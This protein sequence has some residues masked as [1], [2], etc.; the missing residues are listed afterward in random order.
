[1]YGLTFRAG[2]LVTRFTTDRDAA[3]AENG[4]DLLGLDHPLVADLLAAHRATPSSAPEH[5][6]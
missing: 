5:A 3:N 1:M 2:A 6:S 4:T